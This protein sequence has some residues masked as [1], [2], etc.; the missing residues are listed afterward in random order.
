MK[1]SF[2]PQKVLPYWLL[3]PQLVVIAVFFYWP[4]ADA[5]RL[6]FFLEDPFGFS[7]TFVGLDNFASLLVSENY[8]SVAGFTLLFTVVVVTVSL[9][10][11]LLL[12]VQADAV[13]RGART[14][15]TLLMWTYAIAPPVAG[16]MG[17]LLFDQHIGPLAHAAQAIGWDLRLGADY[18]STGTAMMVVA[19]WN[20]LP[21]NFIFFLS[22]LQGIPHSVRE[23]ALMDCRSDTRRFW[24]ITFPLL[25]PTCFFLTVIATTHALFDTFG[26]VDVLTKNE[27]GNNPIT[28]VY[29]IYLDGFR[30]NDLGGSSAQ[31]VLLMVLVLLITWVQ[32]R[33][34]DKKI[35]YQ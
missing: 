14:Y 16:L 7:S 33:L 34:I 28:L 13:L 22:G 8:R 25:A 19:I 6:S 3:M 10:L 11:A 24:T 17:V 2:F 18:W 23:A 31:S 32:F 5:L 15:R 4:A 29:K 35:H 9:A 1:S 30:G 27:P 21:I 12:A 20:Q 26:L